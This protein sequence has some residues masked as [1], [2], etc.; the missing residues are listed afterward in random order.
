MPQGMRP[1][2]PAGPRFRQALVSDVEAIAALMWPDSASQGGLLFGDFPPEKIRHW[3]LQNQADDMPVVLAEDASG[4]LGV[5]FSASAER[6]DT[7]LLA[8]LAALHQ[9]TEPFYFYGPICVAA[10]ARGQGL[11]AALLA[12]VSQRLP[13]RRALLFIR[14]DNP[15]S[16]KAHQRLGL[17]VEAGF[18]HE[19]QRFWLLHQ[20]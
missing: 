10:R 20:A 7:P 14:A 13:G 16:L 5:V 3:L 18:E 12:Q 4:L 6:R 8:T 11:P 19:G 15:A 17:V 1:T 2:D 9:G